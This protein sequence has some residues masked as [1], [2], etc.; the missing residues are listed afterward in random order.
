ML[1]IRKAMLPICCQVIMIGNMAPC[2]QM[3]MIGNMSNIGNMNT[4]S[5]I[6]YVTYVT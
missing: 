1:P 6:T 4:A 5:G 2:C 3:I